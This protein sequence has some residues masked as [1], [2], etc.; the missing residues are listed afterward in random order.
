MLL[1]LKVVAK[2]REVIAILNLES[3]AN[4]IIV[5][6]KMIEIHSLIGAVA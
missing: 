3:K 6:Q 5:K 4:L 1:N 2:A